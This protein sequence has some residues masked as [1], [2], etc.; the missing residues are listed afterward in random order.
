[1]TTL[2]GID[3]PAPATVYPDDQGLR[4]QVLRPYRPNCRYLVSAEVHAAA[5]QV[6]VRGKFRISESC[7]I[8]DTGHFN[9]VEFNICFNQAAYYLFASC[10][11]EKP[12]DAFANWTMADYCEHQLADMLIYRYRCQ[13][14]RPINSRSFEGEI[15]FSEPVVRAREGK[16]PMMLISSPCRFWD[17]SGGRADGEVTLAVINLP[18]GSGP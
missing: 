15:T 3:A 9:A 5:D 2:A 12:F 7:Y 4:Q 18:A 8:D 16:S 13:F 1:M 6:T 10:V 11:R 14:R 17:A